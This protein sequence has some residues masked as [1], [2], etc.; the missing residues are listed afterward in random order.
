MVAKEGIPSHLHNSPGPSYLKRGR[1]GFL[2]LGQQ[3]CQLLE[4]LR[5]RPGWQSAYQ[6][7][8]SNPPVQTL[9]LVR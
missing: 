7:G 9:N 8:I 5:D 2:L 1:G 6:F 3:G 4:C